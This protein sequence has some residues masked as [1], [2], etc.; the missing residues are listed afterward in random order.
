MILNQKISRMLNCSFNEI[1]STAERSIAKLLF[2]ICALFLVLFA[3]SDYQNTKL[4]KFSVD[5]ESSSSG[6]AQVYYDIGNGYNEKDSTKLKINK[7]KF[8]N[9]NFLIPSQKIKSIRFDPIDKYSLIKFKNT[10]IIN[11]FGEI[12]HTFEIDSFSPSNQINGIN[13]ENGIIELLIQKNANDPVILLKDSSLDEVAGNPLIYLKNNLWFYLIIALIFY[14]LIPI[15]INIL[16]SKIKVIYNKPII[17]IS[18]CAFISTL[19]SIYPLLFGKSLNYAAGLPMLYDTIG[20]FPG[21]IFDGFF[22]DFRGAD[23]AAHSWSMS[24]NSTVMYRA[25]FQDHEFPFWNRYVG[26]GVPLWGQG[27]S[28]LGDPLHWL[29]I[30]FNGNSIAWDLKFYLSKFLFALGIGLLG[31]KITSK[32]Y[33]GITIAVLAPFIGFYTFTFNHPIYFCLTYAPWYSLQWITISKIVFYDGIKNYITN[34]FKIFLLLISGWLLLNSG[35][36]KETVIL[37]SFITAWGSALILRSAPNANLSLHLLFLSTLFLTILFLYSPYWLLFLSALDNAKTSYDFI[38]NDSYPI[39]LV[40]GFFEPIIFQLWKGKN[41]VGPSVNLSILFLI[42]ASIN[43][44]NFNHYLYKITL[45]FWAISLFFAFGIIPNNIVYILPLVNRIGHTGITFSLPLIIFSLIIASY[46]INSIKN[47]NIHRELIKF[48]LFFLYFIISFFIIS[49][50]DNKTL[51]LIIFN[52]VL[53]LLVIKK[54]LINKIQIN[55][56]FIPAI[57]I[58]ILILTFK[59]GLN[60]PTGS[61]LINKFVINPNNRMDTSE[62]SSSVDFAK[63]QM[64]SSQRHDRVIGE[65]LVL[66]P[67]VN[68]LFSLETIG[69]PE[70]LKNPNLEKFLDLTGIK[71]EPGWGW[72]RK[73]SHETSS[74]RLERA[75]DLLGVGYI[76]SDPSA[77]NTT[78]LS[79]NS[80]H[81]LIHSSDL[82]VSNREGVWPKAFFV[83]NSIQMNADE[84]INAALDLNQGP[85]AAILQRDVPSAVLVKDA[86]INNSFIAAKNYALTNNSTC[87]EISPKSAGIVVLGEGY[88]KD[89]FLLTVNNKSTD[90]FRVNI[91][92]KGFYVPEGGDYHACYRYFPKYVKLTVLGAIIGLLLVF[93]LPLLLRNSSNE[94]C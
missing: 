13:Y 47:N 57:L 7:G 10:N 74:E 73:Y 34:F 59:N 65:N 11:N 30:F 53:I 36:P 1:N 72:L 19:L 78:S 32:T 63:N 44:E 91:W 48:L 16:I 45:I 92:Q 93:S 3:Y 87:F 62:K 64:S 70:A 26:G 56:I 20:W 33:V 29:T 55:K 61:M 71:A 54:D 83:S 40:V 52:S 68:S 94:K 60:L 86:K 2:I 49:K 90:Y 12:K 88:Y 75:Y 23:V 15:I 81:K 28:M 5:I 58:V 25:I 42:I 17:I 27:Y 8:Y 77:S 51:C 31:Y 6:T 22:E 79:S 89:D 43:K 38:S 66:I 80:N 24:P 35:T 41:Y 14:K 21:Y 85:F 50:F 84:E 46:G 76:F 82:N 39:E 9:Y 37:F 69:S 18:I 4:R 67:G